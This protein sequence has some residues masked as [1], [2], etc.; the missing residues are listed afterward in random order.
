MH[1]VEVIHRPA[2]WPPSRVI[3]QHNEG[4]HSPASSAARFL[5][6]AQ[7]AELLTLEID[8]ILALLHE[9]ALRGVRLGT[10][11]QWRV[12]QDSVADYIDDQIEQTRRMQLWHQ[13]NAASF[14]ELWGSG[15]VRHSD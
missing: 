9:G 5:T 11:A 2:R 3:H 12:E 6:L 8:E 4:M 7:A 14:P 13:S 10:S 1:G 15:A